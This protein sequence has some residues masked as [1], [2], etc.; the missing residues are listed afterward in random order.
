M[1]IA[2][3]YFI[4]YNLHIIIRFELELDLIEGKLKVR[5]VPRAWKQKMKEYLGITPRTNK[6]GCLQDVHWS[7]GILG[8]F[9]TYTIGNIYAAQLYY[10]MLKDKPDI[11][12]DLK[13]GKYDRILKW[14]RMH[15]HKY[16]RTITAEEIVEKATG[17]GLNP[18]VLIKYLREKYS[19][20]YN[21]PPEN[22]D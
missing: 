10:A 4:V 7:M 9:P 6:E 15:V 11:M 16:G 17:E 22:I 13:R 20:I 1:W 5:Q 14:M 18:K 12:N 2:S 19:K 21:L 3:G 8:Y